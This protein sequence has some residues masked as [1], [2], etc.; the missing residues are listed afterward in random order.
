MARARPDPPPALGEADTARLV[1]L[2]AAVPEGA[3]EGS[4]EVQLLLDFLWDLP[5]Y[6]VPLKRAAPCYGRQWAI[7]D[8]GEMLDGLRR[9]LEPS[10]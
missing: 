10:A 8:I 7:A 2:V 9:Y 4:P 6:L 5:P 3:D 1:A